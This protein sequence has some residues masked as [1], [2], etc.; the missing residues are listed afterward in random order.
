MF[1]L[2]VRWI[3]Y[4]HLDLVRHPAVDRVAPIR[5]RAGAFADGAPSR[6]LSLSPGHAVLREGVL[7]PV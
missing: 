6:D 7:I 1:G 4:R 2:L 5:I 3:G